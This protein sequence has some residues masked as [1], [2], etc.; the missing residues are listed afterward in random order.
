M[1]GGRVSGA[2]WLLFAEDREWWGSHEVLFVQ[3]V[4]RRHEISQQA[5]GRLM[6][7]VTEEARSGVK[8]EVD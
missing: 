2:D 1:S 3:R 7:E 4:L 8:V 6:Y 5:P